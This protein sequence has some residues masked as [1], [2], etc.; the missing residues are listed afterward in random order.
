[1]RCARS[2]LER[3]VLTRS[4]ILSTRVQHHPCRAH[5]IPPLLEALA[6]FD[7]VQ[8]VPDP[9]WD[10]NQDAWRAHRA[11]LE[12]MPD[13]ATHLLA[14]QDDILP[15]HGFAQKVAQGIEAHP[16]QVLL[17]FVPGFPRERRTQMIAHKAKQPFAPFIIGAYVPTVAIVYPRAVV[18]GLLAWA[19]KPGDRYRRPLRGADDGIVANYCRTRRIHPLMM[20]PCAVEHD[21]SVPS[22]GKGTRHGPH[23]R[24]ALL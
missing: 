21:E 17:A 10:Q 5:L 15:A 14:V 6:D 20:V 22:V 11:C 13:V 9:G 18:E 16:E 8:V 7:D 12:A 24:A 2:P 3:P 1:M 4:L 23:R 19:D